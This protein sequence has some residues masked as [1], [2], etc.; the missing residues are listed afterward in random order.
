MSFLV[1][2][3]GDFI[4]DTKD[5][6]IRGPQWNKAQMTLLPDTAHSR[7]ANNTNL[8]LVQSVE[9]RAICGLKIRRLK[10]RQT[11]GRLA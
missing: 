1:Q 6:Q 9:I 11:P 7:L 3:C 10:T 5:W 2:G 8:T 4:S